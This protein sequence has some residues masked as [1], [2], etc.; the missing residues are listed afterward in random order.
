MKRTL[1]KG[2]KKNINLRDLNA[3]GKKTTYLL[4]NGLTS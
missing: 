2:V 1:I 4:H 3:V